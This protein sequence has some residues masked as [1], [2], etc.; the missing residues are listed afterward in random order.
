MS[1]PGNKPYVVHKCEESTEN[2]AGASISPG[3]ARQDKVGEVERQ[4]GIGRFGLC[5][6]N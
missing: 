3:P 1:T 5:L 2:M 4:D 6:H